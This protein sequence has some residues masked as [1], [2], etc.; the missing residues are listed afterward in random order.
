MERTLSW[1][2][3]YRRL[4]EDYEY[5]KSTSVT[6]VQMAM[7]HVMLQRLEVVALTPAAA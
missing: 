5:W 6:M 7:S 3:N 4:S 1:I 2:S